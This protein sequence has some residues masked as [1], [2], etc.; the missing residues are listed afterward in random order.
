[1][2]LAK[3]RKSRVVNSESSSHETDA[4][5]KNGK[6]LVRPLEN[7]LREQDSSFSS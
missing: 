1:M 7:V 5:P 3:K 2:Q 6:W 4:T